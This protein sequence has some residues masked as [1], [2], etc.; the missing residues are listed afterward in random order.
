MVGQKQKAPAGLISSSRSVHVDHQLTFLP[1][2]EPGS[3]AAQ[4]HGYMLHLFQYL[5]QVAQVGKQIINMRASMRMRH[6]D[7]TDLHDPIMRGISDMGLKKFMV[8]ACNTVTNGDKFISY[9]ARGPSF[10]LIRTYYPTATSCR[11]DLQCFL[12]HLLL[13]WL[14]GFGRLE[15]ICRL[16]HALMVDESLTILHTIDDVL[17]KPLTN[18]NAYGSLCI[19]L[20]SRPAI[21]NGLYNL[22]KTLSQ[23]LLGTTMTFAEVQDIIARQKIPYMP[24]TGL[25]PWLIIC[26]LA[27]YNLCMPPTIKDLVNK[28][29]QPPFQRD[30]QSG[31]GGSGLR[32][33]LLVVQE[34]CNMEMPFRTAAQLQLILMQVFNALNHSVGEEC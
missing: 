21:L 17:Q 29:G 32:G 12:W 15:V 27:E 16:Y 14:F 23:R 31:T 26:D 3:P 25:L 1:T 33:A 24:P 9:R 10:E 6:R 8:F 5:Y 28:I 18:I 13:W 34:E 20:E 7:K 30:G 19:P 4:L 11:E 22:S 2:V